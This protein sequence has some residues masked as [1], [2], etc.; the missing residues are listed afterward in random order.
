M[1]YNKQI[2]SAIRNDI[3]AALNEIGKKYN[4]N[5]QLGKCR[6]DDISFTINLDGNIITGD[7]DKYRIEFEKYCSMYGLKPTHYKAPLDGGR[8]L[9]VGFNLKSPKFAL[10][11]IDSRTGIEYKGSRELIKHL[12]DYSNFRLTETKLR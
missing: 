3:Q 4:T 10:K 6:Y 8:Y 5:L 7:G 1:G 9:L 12:E 11:M 2:V